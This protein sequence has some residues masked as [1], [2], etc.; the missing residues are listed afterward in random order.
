MDQTVSTLPALESRHVDPHGYPAGVAF[1]DGQY[2]PMSQA[3]I[4]VL[5]WGFLHSDA[6]YDTVHVW[7]GRFFRL[8]LHIERFFGGLERLRMSIPYTQKQV[9]EILHNCVAL[10]GHRAAYV[11]M[12]CTRGASPTFS[13]DPRDAINRFMAFA[14][15]FGS[16]ANAEQRERGLHVAI[17]DRI[18]I[19]P[20]SVDPAIK[21]Y[22]WLDLV[23]GLYDAYDRKAET[24]LLLDFNGNVAEG[25][26]FNVFAVKEGRLVTPAVGVLAGI[27]RRAVFEISGEL[28]LDCNA[29]DVSVAALKGAD[30]VFIT[31]TAGGIMPVTVIDGSPIANG[32]VGPVTRRL[33][34]LYWAKHEDPVWSS[35]VTYPG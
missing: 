5:D 13:R 7:N 33:E 26:G 28:G 6:T 20:A 35:P 25:P 11:E 17:S 18:R 24:A 21:N 12:L 10:S 1:L 27:T 32:K 31:S 3:K 4:S 2:L 34:K 23:R 16:V 9:A 15:P 30:E 19:P 8:D 29:I 22:H 14:V